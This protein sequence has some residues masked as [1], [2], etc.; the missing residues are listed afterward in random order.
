[1]EVYYKKT[2]IQYVELKKIKPFFIIQGTTN[3]WNLKENAIPIFES[4]GSLS[5][6]SKILDTSEQQVSVF[7]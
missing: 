5:S 6:S 3:K 2:Q 7:F 4:C 1:M